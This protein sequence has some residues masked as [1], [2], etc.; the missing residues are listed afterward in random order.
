MSYVKKAARTVAKGKHAHVAPLECC[1]PA[2][3]IPVGAHLLTVVLAAQCRRLTMKRA[4]NHSRRRL[5]ANARVNVDLT[6]KD[7]PNMADICVLPVV[8]AGLQSHVPRAL[9]LC[10]LPVNVDGLRAL[11]DK[12]DGCGGRTAVVD[13]LQQSRAGE[14]SVAILKSLNPSQP[15]SSPPAGA[16][17]AGPTP[18]T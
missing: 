8:A 16:W 17:C 13:A 2:L 3:S 11:V 5:R 10:I 12:L 18:Q 15:P 4:H 14:Q 7:H 6:R 9:S 1:R